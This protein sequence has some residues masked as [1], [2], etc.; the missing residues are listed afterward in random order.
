MDADPSL[1]PTDRDLRSYGLG[2]LDE[3]SSA[4]VHEHLAGCLDCR[5]RVGEMSADSFLDR[6]RDAQGAAGRRSAG[7]PEVVET[8][9]H[10]S[11]A[12]SPPPPA[13]TL[14]PGLAD[15]PDYEIVR[16]LGRGGM[17]VVYLAHNRLMGRD[18]VLKVMGREIVERPGVL[19]RFL[20]EIRAVAKLRHANIVAAYSAVRI[21]ESIVFAMEYVEGLDLSRMVK[22]KGPMPV[23]H[24]CLFARQAALGLQHAHEEGLVH[25]D[26]KPGNLML[27]RRGDRATVKV[28]DFGLAK[29]TREQKLDAGLTHEG[30]ALG[31]PDYI[32]PE[33]ILDAPNADIRADIYSLGGTLY[34]LLTGRPPFRASSLYDIYQAHIS[35]DADPLNLVRPEVPAELAALVAKLMAKDPARRF[36]APAEVAEALTPFFRGGARRVAGAAAEVS[37][38]AGAVSPPVPGEPV[39]PS[40]RVLARPQASP[41]PGPKAPPRPA[42]G[43]ASLIDFGEESI[44]IRPTSAKEP[45]GGGATPRRLRP[46]ALVAVGTLVLGL[47]L[48]GVAWTL[49]VRTGEGTIVIEG[50]PQDAQVSVDG[51]TVTVTRAGGGEPAKIS[52]KPGERKIRVLRGEVELTSQDVTV[53]SDGIPIRVRLDETDAAD[54]GTEARNQ[55]AE[56]E[57]PAPLRGDEAAQPTAVPGR[58]SE[59]ENGMPRQEVA[60]ATPV[61]GDGGGDATGFTPLFN[62]RDFTGWKG[63]PQETGHW[64]IKGGAIIGSGPIRSH[65]YTTRDDYR[66]FH[67]RIE[68]RSN[69]VGNSGVFF[70]SSYGPAFPPENPTFPLGYEAQIN[71][72]HRDPNKTGSLYVSGF[73]AVVSVTEPPLDSSLWVTLEVIAEGNHITIKVNGKTTADYTD[74]R[75]LFAS[76]HIALQQHNPETIVE[77]RKVEIRELND[78]SQPFGN[79]SSEPSSL[80]SKG[81]N[82]EPTRKSSDIRRKGATESGGLT[83]LFSEEGLSGLKEGKENKGTWQVVDGVLLIQ[84]GALLMRGTSRIPEGPAALVTKRNDYSNFRLRVVTSNL[85]GKGKQIHLRRSATDSVNGYGVMVCSDTLN[86][87]QPVGVGSI[88]KYINHPY[89]AKPPMIIGASPSS[90]R[91]GEWYILEITVVGNHITT[92]INGRKVAEY[93]DQDNSYD[94]GE[95]SFVCQASSMIQYKQI[96]VEELDDQGQ[97]IHAKH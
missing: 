67:L 57:D 66:D 36:Q 43:W 52:V 69:D 56:R 17:G 46:W 20:R 9:E 2:R 91:I 87:P 33:Q 19:E 94:K 3:S 1:H 74:E 60:S 15:H 89:R 71:R 16:E 29:A 24:A 13:E 11:A 64:R 35:R 70:R 77:F 32:A 81:A 7:R 85:D 30:Q 88:G 40:A 90:I 95:I 12:A 53:A 50:L 92:A 5:R 62:G 10:R 14:P 84:G 73:G 51:D 28:L 41:I 68:A 31:T 42:E 63:H 22:L 6:V 18:E 59:T 47:L 44:S 61:A 23:A 97:P 83:P 45:E 49:R 82:E 75:R 38:G 65:L 8:Q 4:A 58:T 26:I 25:R 21:G 37:I 54:S 96:L 34:Y 72:L 80:S 48:A 39:T 76:G 55:V 93:T 79:P 27:S 78:S 86:N